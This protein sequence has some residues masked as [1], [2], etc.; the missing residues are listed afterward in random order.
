VQGPAIRFW[1]SL[2]NALHG[3]FLMPAGH[4]ARDHRNGNASKKTNSRT[5]LRARFLPTLPTVYLQ[6]ALP[7]YT[8][9]VHAIHCCSTEFPLHTQQLYP[10][11]LQIDITNITDKEKLNLTFRRNRPTKQGRHHIESHQQAK[12]LAVHFAKGRTGQIAML[13]KTTSWHNQ[14]RRDI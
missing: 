3:E 10:S 4:F 7:F 2:T 5:C 1:P 12:L 13:P 11:T 6:I 8:T 14:V 9:D